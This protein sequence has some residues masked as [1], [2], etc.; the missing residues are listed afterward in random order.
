M[1]IY[2]DGQESNESKTTLAADASLDCDS[3]F[4]VGKAHDDTGF[5]QGA[6]DYLRV[7]QGTL[8]DAQTDI[9]EL[10]EWQ[11]NGPFLYDFHG[12]KPKGE[13]RDAGALE[14]ID[15]SAP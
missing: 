5:F 4:F 3:D 13:R 10:Y 7:C 2:L 6:I 15:A 1:T 12:R 9:A 11:T 14:R 8:A